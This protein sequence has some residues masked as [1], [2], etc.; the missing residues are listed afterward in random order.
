MAFEALSDAGQSGEN[1]LVILNDNQMC[2]DHVVGGLAHHF[3]QLRLTTL[4]PF[5]DDVGGETRHASL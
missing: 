4:Y 5:E 1:L 3:E 2:I